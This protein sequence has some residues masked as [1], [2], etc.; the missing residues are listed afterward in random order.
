MAVNLWNWAVTK[1]V[2]F[3]I[4]E[5]QKAKLRHVA[6]KLVHMC[7]G[8]AASEEAIRRQIF[9]NMRTGKGW[10]D[11]GNAIVADEFFQAAMAGLEQ[12][13]VKLM[14]RSSTEAHATMPKIAVERDLFKVLS[15]QAE[16]AIAQEDFQR[17][18]TCVLR[19]KDML[20]RVPRMAGSL[21]SLC[22]NFGVE[23]YQKNKYE[24]S[25]FWLSQS[26]DIG[27]M[28]ESSV[29]PEMLAKVLRLLATTYLDWDDREY[30]DKAISAVNLANKV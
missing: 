26:Y 13:Y 19:C 30:Y 28:D 7:E 5:E 11:V 15:Y 24:E 6:C 21:H 22:Y 17:A 9:M 20:M 3:V 14:Q 23:T 18:S 29:E 10:V 4:T 16:S 1:R 2:D 12:L 8:S 25:S 27:K